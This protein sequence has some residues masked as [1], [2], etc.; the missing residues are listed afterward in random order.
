MAAPIETSDPTTGSAPVSRWAAPWIDALQLAN[1]FIARLALVLAVAVVEYVGTWLVELIV[2][3]VG[4]LPW[5]AFVIDLMVKVFDI[6]FLTQA[7]AVATVGAY[8]VVRRRI[9]DS[10][11]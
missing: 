3:L 2:P 6:V 7:A 1:E 5:A 9:D 4:N 8:R 11:D 10:A